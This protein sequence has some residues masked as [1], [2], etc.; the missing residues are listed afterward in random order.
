MHVP[1]FCLAQMNR[2]GEDLNEDSETLDS[3]LEGSGKIEQYADVIIFILGL[4]RPGIVQ[5]TLV[6]HKERHREA[7]YR[8]KLDFNQ[9]VMTFEHSGAWATRAQ[10]INAA[11]APVQAPKTVTKKDFF[12]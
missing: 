10:A 8:I 11:S 6:L 2:E 9:P 3:V 1:V 7:G 5:R 4:R 12:S